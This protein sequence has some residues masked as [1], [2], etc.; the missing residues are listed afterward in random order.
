[1]SKADSLFADLRKRLDE[2]E[3]VLEAALETIDGLAEQQ[4]VPDE[5]YL[6]TRSRIRE[7]LGRA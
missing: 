4:A 7:V 2:L 6:V 5:W 1:M 3:E